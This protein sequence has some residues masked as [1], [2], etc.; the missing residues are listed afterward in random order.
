MLGLAVVGMV[1]V[2]ACGGSDENASGT[3][4]DGSDA[5]AVTE[6]AA[7]AT[8][9]VDPSPT[10]APTT[11]PVG[12]VA[13]AVDDA[14]P[15]PD[16][17]RVVVLSEEFLLAD[18]LALGVEPI[19]STVSVEEAGIQGIEGHDT[20]GIEV[21]PMT[22]LSLEH[23]ASLEPDTIIALQFWVDQVGADVLAGLGDVIVV[24]D[25]L[26]NRG[27]VEALGELLGREDEATALIEEFE[28]ATAD[29]AATVGDDCAVSLAAIYPGP[30]PAAF[31]AGPWEIPSSILSTGCVLDP[32][33][34]VAE[35]DNNGRVWL[36]LE[37]LGLLDAPTIVLL[38]SDVVEGES[39]AMTEITSNP[40]WA[41]LPAVQADEVVVFDRL[42]Y[43]GMEGQ[44]RFLGEFS[45]LKAG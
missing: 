9:A 40:L 7:T 29:A 38:Q 41:Q 16:L 21:L 35:P 24:P 18:V 31:V 27:Q 36:S 19:A 26:G 33:P 12:T 11:E 2:A 3:A 1:A 34:D 32:G 20:S 10:E 39:D 43:P 14:D 44:I 45:A 22:T 13:P 4:S 25:A 8:D 30:S 15:A 28:T 42:G 17:G 5:S 37:Q 23:L 6:P